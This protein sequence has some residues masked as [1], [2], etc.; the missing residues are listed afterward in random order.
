PA[1]SVARIGADGGDPNIAYIAYAGFSA[2]TP[3]SPGHVFR[4][5]FNPSTRIATF[6]SLDQDLG[7]LPINTLAVDEAKGDVYAGTDFGPIVL[8]KGSAAWE[9]AGVGFPE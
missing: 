1:P 8:R 4:A 5:V 6:T 9:L 2:L 7:D 3:A